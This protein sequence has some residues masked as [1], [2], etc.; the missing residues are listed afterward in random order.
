MKPG[1]KSTEWWLSM[2]AVNLGAMLGAGLLGAEDSTPVRIAGAVLAA[3]GA[4]GYTYSRSKVKVQELASQAHAEVAE[5]NLQATLVASGAQER[6]AMPGTQGP[7]PMPDEP[8][9]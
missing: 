4:W 8:K 9:E 3:L 2:V 7:R 1:F 5:L 6:Q